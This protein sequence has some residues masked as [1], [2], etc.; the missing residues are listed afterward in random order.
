M[1]DFVIVTLH[2]RDDTVSCHFRQVGEK[3]QKREGG[4]KNQYFY[5]AYM[6]DYLRCPKHCVK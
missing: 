1:M 5:H 2:I 6:E 3:R 4:K